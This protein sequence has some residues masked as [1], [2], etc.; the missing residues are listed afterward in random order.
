MYTLLSERFSLDIVGYTSICNN[1][2]RRAKNNN[3]EYYYISLTQCLH[4]R[5]SLSSSPPQSSR[6]FAQVPSRCLFKQLSAAL[7]GGVKSHIL[8]DYDFSEIHFRHAREQGGN[9]KSRKFECYAC[10]S[11]TYI[12]ERESIGI[13]RADRHGGLVVLSSEP[14]NKYT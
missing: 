12:R 10:V 2:G 4:Q 13:R 3:N 7:F 11:T 1:N 14:T 8:T 9:Q 6:P 5:L